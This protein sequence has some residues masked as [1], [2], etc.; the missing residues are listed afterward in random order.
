MTIFG[1]WLCDCLTWSDCLPGVGETVAGY[2]SGKVGNDERGDFQLQIMRGG[3]WPSLST[4]EK[5]NQF[6]NEHM[7]V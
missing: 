4:D 6:L 3:S 7:E 1:D 2:A 5:L